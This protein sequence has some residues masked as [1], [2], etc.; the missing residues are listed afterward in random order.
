MYM[1]QENPLIKIY[2]SYV[3]SDRR[4]LSDLIDTL[5]FFNSYYNVEFLYPDENFYKENLLDV[6]EQ[7]NVPPA[8]IYFI[9]LSNSYLANM[10]GDGGEL[11]QIK[12]RAE[13]TKAK[14]MTLLLEECDWQQLQ[15]QSLPG[16]PLHN[17]SFL[18]FTDTKEPLHQIITAVSSVIEVLSN[19]EIFKVID[20]CMHN[21]D[22]VTLDLSDM[23]LEFVPFELL[24]L[25]KLQ[26][27]KLN[28]NQIKK[29]QHLD[30]LIQLQRLE[31]NKNQITQIENLS[32]LNSLQLLSL[33][34]NQI[35]EIN[36]LEALQQLSSLD[37]WKNNITKI[38]GLEQTKELITLGLSENKI[39]LIEGI[40]HLS[41]LKKIYLSHNAVKDITPLASMPALERIIC[42]NNKINSL[43]PLLKKIKKGLDVFLRYSFNEQEG[44]LFV[45][46][47]P[48]SDPPEEVVLHGRA[49][50]MKHF[51]DTEVDN[52]KLEILKFIIVGNSKVG[53]SNFC[54]FL[55]AKPITVNSSSTHIL[56]IQKLKADFLKSE[57]GTEMELRLFDFGGQDYYH[58]NH[59]MYYSHDT[60]YILLWDTES[61]KYAEK[62]EAIEGLDDIILYDNYP[63]AY[64]LE[65]INYNL[66][67]KYLETYAKGNSSRQGNKEKLPPVLIIQNKIDIA[68]GL[69]NQEELS[70]RYPN[71]WGYYGV[72]LL[73][74][75]R[76]DV[77]KELL[78]DYLSELN[79]SGRVLAPYQKKIVNFFADSHEE[80]KIYSLEEFKQQCIEIINDASVVFADND[81]SVMAHILNNTGIIFL[82]NSVE[83][84]PVVYTNISLLNKEIKRIMDIAR[85]GNEKGVFSVSELD[86]YDD[87]MNKDKILD[88]L[89]ANKS[90]I[91]LNSKQYL[92]PQ[93]LPTEPDPSVKFFLDT[94]TYTQLRYV[95]SA[96]FHKSLLL[97]LFARYINP[98]GKEQVYNLRNNPYWRNGLI[99]TRGE[100][101]YVEKVLVE[102]IKG[103]KQGTIHIRTMKPFSRNGLEREIETVIDE[104]N[105]GWTVDKEVA[106]DSQTFFN[107]EQLKKK[108]LQKEF[109]FYENGKKFRINDFKNIIQFEKRPSRFFISYSTLD[110][111]YLHDFTRHLT[112]LRTE[113]LVETWDDREL[114]AGDKWDT[115]IKEQL[116]KADYIVLLISSNF[117]NSEYIRDVELK[118]ALENSAK[119]VI[120]VIIDYCS[121]QYEER[122]REIQVLNKNAPLTSYQPVSK[123]W[124]E[125]IN[126]IRSI[127]LK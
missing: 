100:S 47:N 124:L 57:S 114:Q 115:I 82:D 42:T 14:I 11:Q 66:K 118:D 7:K 79:L 96:Y 102:F 94:F 81:A 122:L 111:S 119:R 49:A 95:Y 13:G 69:L 29:I 36:N 87:I 86:D 59:R 41:K 18:S 113:G 120:P 71:I 43:K 73:R 83:S 25:G 16:L 44:G 101:S 1:M 75:K 12:H 105:R 38:K 17:R 62:Q 61:N 10:N 4:H 9:V 28:N 107:A 125:V 51:A 8:D 37:L 74:K 55:N 78:S 19:D 20:D 77:L 108:S 52:E 103:D 110:K 97:N 117:L 15:L 91:Q 106:S 35:T 50:I 27:L 99:I 109:E 65:S 56:D 90:I 60:A 89:S 123:G 116:E 112:S 33:C 127:L 32:S 30:G 45:K 126:G 2:F 53:K 63:L 46:D 84:A 23:E 40:G 39:E 6:Q 80:L 76:T 21:P 24:N 3:N 54:E 92:A 48:L 67:G 72:S 70:A 5:P 26:V 98:L 58:D 34:D 93:F 31:M 22:D 121:W 104:L 88:L 68:N 85:K 64:W